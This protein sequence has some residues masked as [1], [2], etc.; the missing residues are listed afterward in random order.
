M[1]IFSCC[2]TQNMNTITSRMLRLFVGAF[3]FSK[4]LEL[5]FSLFKEPVVFRPF[6][7]SRCT[8]RTHFTQRVRCSP[9]IC[10][11][12]CC[13]YMC[14]VFLK[15]SPSEFLQGSVEVFVRAQLAPA[16]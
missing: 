10:K 7:L 4:I 2:V 5:P 14:A 8:K 3:V 1:Y 15:I 16:R 9:N 11:R 12:T 6:G 13:R